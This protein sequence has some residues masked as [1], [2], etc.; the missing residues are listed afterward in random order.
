MELWNKN[1]NFPIKF[2]GVTGLAEE[3]LGVVEGLK[4]LTPLI[5]QIFFN[6]KESNSCY[7]KRIE[8]IEG[9]KLSDLVAQLLTKLGARGI[10]TLLGVRKTVGSKEKMPPA[11]EE[12]IRGFNTPFSRLGEESQVQIISKVEEDQE[13]KK[14]IETKA[15]QLSV[16]ARALMKH[17]HRSS[18]VIYIKNFNR[19]FGGKQKEQNRT[20]MST[21]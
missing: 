20:E 1:G 12:L 7:K 14:K 3:T 4:H 11:T 18:E 17:A 16:G 10:L 8:P 13:S 6:L 19:D 21:Q 2:V 5:N 9:K 15:C